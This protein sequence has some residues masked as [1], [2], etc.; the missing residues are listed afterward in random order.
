MISSPSTL[1]GSPVFVQRHRDA[2]LSGTSE[3]NF[4][5][6]VCE[7][8]ETAAPV[9]TSM[10]R[11]LPLISMS[12]VIEC[13][14]LVES[15]ILN[16]GSSESVSLSDWP[17]QFLF[18]NFLVPCLFRCSANFRQM[19]FLFAIVTNDIF[20]MTMG[21]FVVTLATVISDNCTSTLLG[22]LCST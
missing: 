8:I 21:C 10:L 2:G 16:N 5:H 9:S 22:R 14:L 3:N 18:S 20:T 4:W 13:I 7:I 17:V 12:T 6:T 15:C 1:I 19:S 11:I